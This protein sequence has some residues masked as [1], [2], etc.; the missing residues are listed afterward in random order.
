MLHGRFSGKHLPS[1]RTI[2][3]Y[4]CQ[5]FD[6]TVVSVVLEVIFM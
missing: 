3:N 2:F 6:K 1:C 5:H 4:V